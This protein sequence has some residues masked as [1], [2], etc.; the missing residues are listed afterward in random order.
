MKRI[1]YTLLSA[2]MAIFIVPVSF[3]QDSSAESV[4][5]VRTPYSATVY[6]DNRGNQFKFTVSCKKAGSIVTASIEYAVLN[7]QVNSPALEGVEVTCKI[8]DATVVLGNNAINKNGALIMTGAESMFCNDPMNYNSS[9]L[10]TEVIDCS[11]S[12]YKG[13]MTATAVFSVPVTGAICAFSVETN[14]GIPE[15]TFHLAAS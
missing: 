4:D 13:G 11:G 8:T 3:A 1:F 14:S 7:C 6:Y 12:A 5:I 10:R 9:L 15:I 2:V